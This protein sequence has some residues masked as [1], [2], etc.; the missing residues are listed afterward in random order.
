MFSSIF[1]HQYCIFLLIVV[2]IYYLGIWIIV[3]KAKTP[4]LSYVRNAQRL[5]V[6]N[7]NEDNDVQNNISFVT[8]ELKP[9]FTEIQDCNEL[10]FAL[11]LN[12]QKYKHQDSPAF[13]DKINAFI[14]NESINKC[15][16]R[17][18]EEDLGVLWT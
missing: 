11:R 18:S 1:W 16:V 15:S 10:L 17:L 13:R 9:V 6:R 5:S 7:K 8:E 2:T 12:L 14:I 4:S 3:F